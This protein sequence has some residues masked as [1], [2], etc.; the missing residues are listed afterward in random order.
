[1]KL[2]KF[3]LFFAAFMLSLF[4]TTVASIYALG[5][6]KHDMVLFISQIPASRFWLFGVTFFIISL[7]V[8]TLLM[9]KTFDSGLAPDKPAKPLSIDDPDLSRKLSKLYL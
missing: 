2:I 5:G 7:G 8:S 9:Y 1:M 4:P 3:L 6:G